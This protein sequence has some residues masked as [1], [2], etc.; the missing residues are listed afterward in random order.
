MLQVD[1]KNINFLTDARP[2]KR[3]VNLHASWAHKQ[4]SKCAT[5]SST[6]TL[7][8]IEELPE[9]VWSPQ[10]WKQYVEE[11]LAHND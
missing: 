10:G 1:G 4:A 2:S 11:W 7:G 6:V 9:T 8:D 3:A 5:A